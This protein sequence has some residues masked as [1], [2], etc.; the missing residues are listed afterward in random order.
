MSSE[1][2][3]TDGEVEISCVVRNTGDRAG[4]EVVQLYTADPVARLPRPVTQLTGCSRLHLT[5]P[6]RQVGHDRV[7]R[8]PAHI[9]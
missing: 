9:G 6:V 3:V 8:T 1:K 2:M 5:G 7:L 4:A